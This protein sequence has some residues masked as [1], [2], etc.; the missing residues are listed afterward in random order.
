MRIIDI[1]TVKK[2]SLIWQWSLNKIFLL[3]NNKLKSIKGL[4]ISQE[5]HPLG[6]EQGCREDRPQG[7]M[8]ICE[9]KWAKMILISL[10]Q[11]VVQSNQEAVEI[12]IW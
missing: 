7:W 8:G 12:N 10:H 2:Y 4:I 1:D 11:E 5:G 9:K 3:L 6:K